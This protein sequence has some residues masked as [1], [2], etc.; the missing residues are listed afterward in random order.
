MKVLK[1]LT[2]AAPNITTLTPKECNGVHVIWSVVD[3]TT[4]ELVDAT[5][6]TLNMFVV[7][8]AGNDIPFDVN[9]I[10]ATVGQVKPTTMG[11]SVEIKIQAVGLTTQKVITSLHYLL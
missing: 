11:P 8:P 5:G 1:E 4:N 9:P 10:D 7:G 2:S 6:L 3:G